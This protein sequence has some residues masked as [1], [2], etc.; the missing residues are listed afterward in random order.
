[1]DQL[2]NPVADQGRGGEWLKIKTIKQVVGEE[3][4]NSIAV[5][6]FK[7]H[8]IP[9]LI[10]SKTTLPMNTVTALLELL[11]ALLEC[12]DCV[13]KGE[14]VD[15]PLQLFEGIQFYIPLIHF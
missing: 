4:C 7:L 5:L 3:S 15:L 11:T 10:Y 2:N 14:H 9:N 1:M 13:L 12:Y 6:Y 8:I